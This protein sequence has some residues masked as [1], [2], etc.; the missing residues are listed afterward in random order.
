MKQALIISNSQSRQAISRSN[1][2]V[3]RLQSLGYRCDIVV[4]DS[5]SA[6]RELAR[7]AVERNI[8]TVIAAGGDGTVH[9]IA[10]EL[11]QSD[12]ALGI[13]P[14]GTGNDIARALSIEG[15]ANDYLLASTKIDMAYIPEYQRWFLAVLATGFDARVN[16]TANRLGRGRYI[17]AVVREVASLR[18][19]FYELDIDE[20]VIPGLATMVCVGNLSTYGG[21]MRMCP[22]ATPTDGLLDVTWVD[23]VTRVSL[24]RFLPQV[25]T[26]NHVSMSEVHTWQAQTVMLRGPIFMSYADGEPVGAPPFTVKVIPGAIRIHTPDGR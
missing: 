1:E 4:T 2:L 7:S 6:A 14:V 26:G 11:A 13:I 23:P 21:G 24:L 5:A 10:Q 18:P 16:E 25:F 8:D 15:T 12:T 22:T 19:I 17:R 9:Y 20:R 3:P